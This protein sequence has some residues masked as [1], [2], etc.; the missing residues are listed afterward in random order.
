MKRLTEFL[1]QEEKSLPVNARRKTDIYRQLRGNRPQVI[2][3]LLIPVFGF[4]TVAIVIAA[5]PLTYRS[6]TSFLQKVQAAYEE[7]ATA[8]NLNTWHHVK[9]LRSSNSSQYELESWSNASGNTH[10][11]IFTS[12]NNEENYAL[13]VAGQTYVSKEQNALLRMA[14]AENARLDVTESFQYQWNI[15]SG[16]NGPQFDPLN[17]DNVCYSFEQLDDETREA[18]EVISAISLLTQ[19][20]DGAFDPDR[21]NKLIHLLATDPHVSDIGTQVLNGVAVHGY[22]FLYVP[23]GESLSYEAQYWFD[24]DTYK[25]REYSLTTIHDTDVSAANPWGTT[26][27]TRRA[28]ILVDEMLSTDQLP[29]NLFTPERYQLEPQ[30]IDPLYPSQLPSVTPEEACYWAPMSEPLPHKLPATEEAEVRARIKAAN[31]E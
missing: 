8:L 26:P 3:P 20:E 4:A 30:F 19:T 9:I 27:Q 1:E 18:Q 15:P 29:A 25:L 14:A 23:Q 13:T 22:T 7:S 28:S 16:L 31:G 11:R 21:M 5:L 24:V 6:E 10:L 12:D 17:P 2:W